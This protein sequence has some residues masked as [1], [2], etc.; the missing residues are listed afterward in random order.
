M[1]PAVF[2]KKRWALFILVQDLQ[3]FVHVDIKFMRLRQD[4][5]TCESGKAGVVCGK[6]DETTE[7][8]SSRFCFVQLI[9][10]QK[11]LFRPVISD[12]FEIQP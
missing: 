8:S 5:T 4:G 11:N 2:S 3:K 12:S 7:A 9:F 10:L 1:Q 6:N